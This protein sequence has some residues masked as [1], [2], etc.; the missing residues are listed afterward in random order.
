MDTMEITKIVGAMA[1]AF[2]VFLLI[3]AGSEGIYHGNSHGGDEAAYVIEVE[4]AEEE[5]EDEV[6]VVEVDFSEVY[7]VADASAGERIF[8][9]CAACHKLEDGANAIGPYLYQVVGRQIGGVD[10]FS[11]S[12]YLA[13]H[14]G[15]WTPE[16]LNGFLENPR[17]WAPGT[18]MNY[19]GLPDIEDRANL[20]AYLDSVE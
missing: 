1:G 15:D 4:G 8:R 11:Y 5:A 20:I 2:L 3:N 13:E 19:R 12:T 14:G 18:K 7:A 17:N 6:E 9:A 16:N 10:G